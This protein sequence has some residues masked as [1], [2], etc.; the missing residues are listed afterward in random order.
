VTSYTLISERIPSTDPRCKRHIYHDSRSWAYRYDTRG[1][2]A[3][4][5]WSHK[6]I[7]PILDQGQVGSCTGETGIG[8]LG[9]E[10]LYSGATILAVQRAF[11]SLD[12]AGAYNLYSAEESFDGDGP[13]PPNDNGST[14]L[15]LAKVLQK[16]G[17]ISA[18]K[19]TFSLDD[20]LLAGQDYP[21]ASGTY[22]YNS[23]FNPNPSTGVLTVDPS[24]G[25][26][27]GHEYEVV[28]YDPV[29]GLIEI[30]N[31]WGPNWGLNG[32]CYMQVE[33]WDG[34]LQQQGDVTILLP[35]SAVP[36]PTPTDP[37]DVFAKVAKPWAQGLHTS[38]SGNHHMA[39]ATKTYLKTIGKW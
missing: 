4:Q 24:S 8:I 7:L 38:L 21:L 31:S 10:P 26:A 1:Y 18:Y 22:W 29:R 2:Q 39:V 20:A 23:M 6:R 11:G 30:P 12:Q 19:H 5:P 27:G 35:L 9:T 34:L 14:G 32:R 37:L 16:N 33:D 28:A 15:T 25:I 17:C 3:E 13:Y 36:Q